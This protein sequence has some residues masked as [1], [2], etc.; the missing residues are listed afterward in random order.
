MIRPGLLVHRQHHRDDERAVRPVALDL[1]NLLQVG[2]QRPVGDQ[3]DVVEADDAALVAVQGAVA[4][5]AHIDDRRPGLAE[6]LPNGTAPASLERPVDVV[7]LVGWRRG[8]Q[9]EGIRGL[10]A[11]KTA[12]QVSHCRLPGSG[13]S[14]A[15]PACRAAR[16][17][18][19]GRRRRVHSRRRPR[20]RA[21]MST[22]SR[23]PRS[24]RIR[25]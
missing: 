24:C 14:P 16:Q 4:R 8:C 25:G 11:E 22:G 13:R 1:P 10:D 20:L 7:G 9:P 21:A 19:S 17:S 23:R 18:R 6:R 15:R 12:G 3:F 5:P 2:F